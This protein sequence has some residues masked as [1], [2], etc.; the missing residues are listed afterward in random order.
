MFHRLG[1]ALFSAA[2]TE[3]PADDV[4]RDL[5]LATANSYK[6]VTSSVKAAALQSAALSSAKTLSP[7]EFIS[8]TNLSRRRSGFMNNASMYNANTS[9]SAT[10]GDSRK[11]VGAATAKL[12][13]SG[14]APPLGIP[15]INTALGAPAGTATA[16]AESA[17][18][19]TGGSATLRSEK[20]GPHRTYS[21]HFFE[22]QAPPK[23]K[24]LSAAQRMASAFNIVVPDDSFCNRVSGVLL[25]YKLHLSLACASYFQISCDFHTAQVLI[26]NYLQQSGRHF[27][28]DNVS[29]MICI[30]IC[31]CT[32]RRPRW[33][34]PS[35]T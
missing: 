33:A 7:Q 17:A 13:A 29:L 14:K 32:P 20:N 11:C 6:Q 21:A 9:A 34:R 4:S 22:M 5:E 10:G 3:E 24:G 27:F 23:P 25:E 1:S 30:G 2:A 18:T 26:D 16:T 12:T 31:R 35:D 8:G 15:P 28:F 19:A